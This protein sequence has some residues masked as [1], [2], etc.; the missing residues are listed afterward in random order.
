MSLTR[1]CNCWV[2]THGSTAQGNGVTEHRN[3]RENVLRNDVLQ[4]GG[5]FHP[6]LNEECWTEMTFWFWPCIAYP[7][8]AESSVP[9]IFGIVDIPMVYKLHIRNK[10]P[11]N[12]WHLGQEF[13]HWFGSRKASW[14]RRDVYWE[15]MWRDLLSVIFLNWNKLPFSVADMLTAAYHDILSRMHHNRSTTLP[16]TS[17]HTSV[18]I[19]FLVL[20]LP[21]TKCPNRTRFCW[22]TLQASDWTSFPRPFLLCSCPWHIISYYIYVYVYGQ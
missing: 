11:K 2:A 1:P 12:G 15:N 22:V 16:L 19:T 18:N 4:N 13:P 20:Y 14:A 9:S 3:A 17:K 10:V 8:P 7:G 21:N 6:I 5:T